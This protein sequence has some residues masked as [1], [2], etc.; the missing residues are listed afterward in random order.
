[1]TP[2]CTVIIGGMTGSPGSTGIFSSFFACVRP[3]TPAVTNAL[4]AVARAVKSSGS[5]MPP[6]P[7]TNRPSQT[8]LAGLT[9]EAARE[10]VALLMASGC[11]S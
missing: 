5:S 1:L 4:N 10:I 6:H 7:H 8:P 9:G 2:P 3:N 11:P